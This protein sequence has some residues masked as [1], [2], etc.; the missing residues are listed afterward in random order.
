MEEEDQGKHEGVEGRGHAMAL[1]GVGAMLWAGEDMPSSGK[2]GLA[3]QAGEGKHV[4]TGGDMCLRACMR[5]VADQGGTLRQPLKATHCGRMGREGEEVTRLPMQVRGAQLAVVHA[6]VV[7]G[8][9]E[10]CMRRV[11]PSLRLFVYTCMM[12][13]MEAGGGVGGWQVVCSAG[14]FAVPPPWQKH[15]V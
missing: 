9:T 7:F 2:E 1:S 11:V 8:D 14:V 3:R 15:I 6:G 4:S 5:P 12:L 13:F 10:A